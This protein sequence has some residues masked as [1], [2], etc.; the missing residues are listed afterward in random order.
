MDEGAARR[1]L[2]IYGDEETRDTIDQYSGIKIPHHAYIKEAELM[3]VK[4][5]INGFG[6]VAKSCLRASFNTRM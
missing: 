5:G 2:E 3:T 6:R 1:I 4:V